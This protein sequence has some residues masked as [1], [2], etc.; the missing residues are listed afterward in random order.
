MIFRNL[1]GT[2]DWTFGQGSN[3]FSTGLQAI[4]LDLNTRI[5]SFLGD[6]FWDAGAGADWFNLLGGKSINDVN[7]AVSTIILNTDSVLGFVTPVQ[8]AYSSSTRHLTL[9]YSV[10]TTLGTITVD[11][12]FSVLDF[13]LTEGGDFITDESGNRI[14]IT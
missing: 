3:S 9:S 2:G 6:C 7:L 5:L 11:Q 12:P 13:L 8:V 10:N 4:Q 1:T 14:S